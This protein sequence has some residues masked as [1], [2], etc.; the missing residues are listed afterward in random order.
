MGSVLRHARALFVL[1]LSV[2]VWG[3]GA[4]TDAASSE[5]VGAGRAALARGEH[6]DAIE[7]LVAESGQGGEAA[8]LLARARADHAR[9]LL[10]A[11][12]DEPAAQRAALD[13]LS[14]ALPLAAD[15]E[16]LQAEIRA[17]QDELARLL[18]AETPPSESLPA[19]TATP[20]APPAQPTSPPAIAAPPRRAAPTAR[21]APSYRVVQRQSF[22]GSGN[23]GA[24]ASCVDL[25]VIGANGPVAGA[26]LGINNGDLTYQN[27]T[28]ANGYAGRCGLGASTWSVVL[29]WTPGEGNVRGAVTTI[30][31]NGAPEQRGIAVFQLR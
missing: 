7:L 17:T 29:F 14:L 23:S 21:P 26:V 11:A 15:D 28:D 10:A 1:L 18:T 2:L 12:P 13:Q 8:L 24:F 19:T 27:Q 31:L 22:E 3:C 25:Q 30:Y 9:A 16:A 6:E 5:T 4:S 20:A